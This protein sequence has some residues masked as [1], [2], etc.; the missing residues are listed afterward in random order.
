MGNYSIN[1]LEKLSGV[2]A[3]TIRIWEKR[4]NLIEPSRTETNFRYYNDEQLKKLLN[5][6]LLNNY[7]YKISKIAGLCDGDISKEVEKVASGDKSYDAQIEQLV[8][9]MIEMDEDK[10]DQ[11]M[12]NHILKDGFEDAM[13]NVVYPF[14]DKVGILWQTGN[15]TPAQEHFVT[16]II[17]QKLIIAIDELP[18]HITDEAKSF[19]LFLPE[20]EFHEI[21]LLYTHFLLRK[22]GQRV[23][24]LGQSLPIQDIANVVKTKKVDFIITFIT[25]PMLGGVKEYVNSLQDCCPNCTIYIAGMQTSEIDFESLNNVHCI[26]SSR[27]VYSILDSL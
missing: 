6:S 7:G 14:F 2:K 27:D 25:A 4:F 17:R 12:T 5:I 24:Y 26:S 10:F 15:V 21:G 16:A 23:T 8:V 18:K 20:K 13:Q 9:S 22:N 11:Q 1:D 3:H 19:L